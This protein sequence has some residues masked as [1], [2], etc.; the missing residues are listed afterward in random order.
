MNKNSVG[1]RDFLKTCLAATAAV[2]GLVPKTSLASAEKG[3]SDASYDAKGLPT[4]ILGRTGVAVPIIGFGGGSRFCRIEDPE[5]SVE[6][7]T[8]ALD[9][10][11]YYWDTANQYGGKDFK[12]EERYGLVLKNRRREVFLATKVGER[13]YDGA[14]RQLEESL[15][16]LQTDHLDIYQVHSVESPADVEAIGAKGGILEALR[17]LREQKV[18]RFIGFSGHADAEAMTALINRFDFD[19]ML[20][21]LNHY[22][23]RKGDFE[24]GAIPAAAA[25]NMGIMAIKVIRPQE[26]VA[27]VKPDE[28]IRYALSLEH[29][30]SAVIGHD[31]LDVLKKNIELV[32]N[33]QKMSAAEMQ[34]MRMRLEPFFAGSRLPWMQPGYT[35]GVSV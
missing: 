17:K 11:L 13:T 31:S 15:K 25:K 26:T 29:L 10:G 20:I 27:G 21:A 34:D 12:S 9:H 24:K 22:A 35:D 14:M 19:T 8:H 7:I 28:L 18:T 33:F 1:R 23:E 5:K 30:H 4:R 6:V 16:R 2:G 3:A 32:K